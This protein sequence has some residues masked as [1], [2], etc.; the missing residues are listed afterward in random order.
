M[1]K[2]LKKITKE[3]S[4]IEDVKAIILYGSLARKEYTSRSDID[5]FILTTRKPTLKHVQD[6]II[7]LENTTGRSIQPTIRTIKE[8]QKTDTGLLQ[9]I[10]QEGK[11]LYL[12]EATEI[13]SAVLLEQKPYLIYSFQLNNLI[14]N[15]KARFNSSFYGRVKNKYKY[16]GLLNEI[17]GQK[18]SPGCVI[19]PHAEKSKV[20]RFFRGFKIKFN[21]LKIWK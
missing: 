11:L 15:E 19:I 5:L 17:N 14:Q 18:L 20:E 7:E 6:K 16:T 12:K 3:L 4:A 10:F 2:I 8:L 1:N 9:N 13:P 21:Q